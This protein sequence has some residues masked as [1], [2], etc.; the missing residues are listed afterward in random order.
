MLTKMLCS[1]CTEID[2]PTLKYLARCTGLSSIFEI[3]QPQFSYCL[4]A[5]LALVGTCRP[6]CLSSLLAS[7]KLNQTGKLLTS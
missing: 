2:I 4:I 5:L 6:S 7:Y 3:M 1:L